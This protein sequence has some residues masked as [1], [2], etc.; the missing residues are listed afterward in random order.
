MIITIA[1]KPGSGKSVVA[2]RLAKKLKIKHFN[3]G[4]VYRKFAKKRH[5]GI[6]ELNKYLKTHHKVDKL[7]DKKQMQLAKKGNIIIDGRTAFNIL[8]DSI[9]IFLDVSI[10][11]AA[12]RIFKAKR[13]LENFKSVNQVKK[14]IIKR[15]QMERKR[16]K[17]I[18]KVD[19]YD[20]KHYDLY[21]RTSNLTINQVV[22]TI[23]KFVKKNYK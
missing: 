2:K 18:Y 6:I 23:V 8:P 11:E 13:K 3:S 4:S 22:N 10:H 16:Y 20:R 14:S 19:I 21:L 15:A 5:M 9:K 17:N 7:V 12:K 1:G